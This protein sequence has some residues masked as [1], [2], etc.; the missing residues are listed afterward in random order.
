MRKYFP[1]L[2]T[3]EI[4]TMKITIDVT[5]LKHNNNEDY[6]DKIEV[7]RAAGPC[8]HPNPES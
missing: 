1:I 8:T 6:S 5:T 2:K 4:I 7:T 3:T